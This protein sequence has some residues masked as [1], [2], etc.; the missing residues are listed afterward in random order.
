MFPATN[1]ISNTNVFSF[2]V[3][4]N[5][6][7]RFSFLFLFSFSSFPRTRHFNTEMAVKTNQMVKSHKIYFHIYQIFAARRKNNIYRENTYSLRALCEWFLLF[8]QLHQVLFLC[9]LIT[10]KNT[11]TN[12]IYL[13]VYIQVRNFNV[14]LFAIGT[15][16]TKGRKDTGKIMRYYPNVI[17][18]YLINLM[19]FLMPRSR[20][21]MR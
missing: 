15:M 1:F 17:F 5:E 21:K 13:F 11:K 9:K 12:K 6:K 4:F 2:D 10:E 18:I 16:K 20:A 8:L 3:V 19:L 7:V 14:I